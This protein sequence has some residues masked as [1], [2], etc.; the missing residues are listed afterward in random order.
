MISKQ[1]ILIVADGALIICALIWGVS[2]ALM[3]TTVEVVPPNYLLALRFFV[4]ALGLL[5]FVWKKLA[6]ADI[7]MLLSGALLGIVT[8]LAFV[9]Q[10]VGLMHTTAGKN[11][12][13]TTVYVILAPFSS[14]LFFKKRPP[15]ITFFAAGVCF[16]GIAVLSLDGV[17]G[18]NIGDALTLLCG[19]LF[20]LQL[21]LVERFTL[22]GQDVTLLTMLQFAVAGVAAFVAG[23]F[24][25]QFS[26]E[27]SPATIGTLTFLCLFATLL[28]YLLQNFGIKHASSAHASLLL[29]FESLFG[30][31]SGVVILGEA[32]TVRIAIGGGL[33]LAATILSEMKRAKAEARSV[34]IAEN[35][36][37]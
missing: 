16:L 11:A 26:L 32:F 14:W 33:I 1:R 12:F 23:L 9:A 31:L 34:S 17:G 4:G 27:L 24:T 2:F 30:C 18:F 5:P 8:Y 28:A 29:G 7:R 6:K 35:A 21:S 15:L 20:A 13:I 3:K 19:V 10:T 36:K 25:E 22:Q 37:A